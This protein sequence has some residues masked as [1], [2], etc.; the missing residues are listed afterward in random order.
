MTTSTPG[1]GGQEG[2]GVAGGAGGGRRGVRILATGSCLPDRRLTNADLEKMMDTSDEWI[3]QRTGIRERRIIDPA[4][5]EGTIW[6]C[7]NALGRAIKNAGVAPSELDM[8][9]VAT[10]SM[11]M[12]CPST[13]CRVAAKLGCGTAGA[14]DLTAACC[15]F[16]YA[17]NFAH[18]LIKG[19]AY[20]TIGVIGCDVL[21]PLMDYT[22][23]GRGTAII[24]GDAAGA[25]VLRATDDASKGIIAQSM[26]SD[27]SGWRHLYI[28]R[29]DS[30]FPEGVEP[31]HKKFNKMI[32]NGRE[33]FKFAVST[34]QE[35]IAETLQKAGLTAADIDHFVCHQSNARILEAARE[36]FGIP[37]EKMYVNI[38]RVGNT[39]AGSVPVC[40]DELR[41]AGRIKEGQLVMLVAFGGGLTWA[42]SLWRV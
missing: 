27:G 41:A 31:D 26:H 14:V 5:G 37:H 13:S 17:M 42:S 23:E 34:F 15:G 36:R 21:T 18:D 22:T 1:T 28:P 20:R 12:T 40:L 30:D 35:L 19:G 4:K 32:M 10:V 9:I 33:V 7:T 25:A 39:S 3:V 16:V 8:V 29:H 24:F 38:D 11:E 6:L 2:L